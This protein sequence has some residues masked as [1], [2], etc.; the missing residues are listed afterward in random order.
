[1]ILLIKISD[2]IDKAVKAIVGL[3]LFAMFF[4][5]V[6]QVCLRYIFKS[7]LAWTDEIARYMMTWLVF[8]GA[9][10]ASRTNSH[11][12]VTI[13]YDKLGKGMQKILLLIINIMVCA[14]LILV[15]VQGIELL[16]MVKM[17]RSA[18]LQFSMAIPYF[19]VPVGCTLMCLQT[20]ISTIIYICRPNI[21][22]ERPEK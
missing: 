17:T 21:T 1:M 18:V 2:Y 16:K 5:V 22:N 9:C 12:G 15:A 10:V 7:P 20:I 6:L 8:I 11:L 3:L 4:V 13:L 19:S 14:F